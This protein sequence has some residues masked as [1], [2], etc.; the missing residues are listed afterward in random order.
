MDEFEPYYRTYLKTVSPMA[1]SL[2]TCELLA[3]LCQN[4]PTGFKVLDLGSGFSSFY[5]ANLQ[6][7]VPFQLWSVDT[8][9]YWLRKTDKF[10]NAYGL[11]IEN[12][13]LWEE[14]IKRCWVK[15]QVVFFD[16]DRTG[17]RM[18]YLQ[19]ALDNYLAPKGKIVLDDMHKKLLQGQ[20]P[21]ILRL[22]KYSET[23]I[24]ER[25]LDEYG[26]YCRLLYNIER[27]RV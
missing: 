7:R 20:L 2:M 26:R 17:R 5:L 4:A 6:K 12:L 21:G 14:F 24:K 25:T 22:Y 16:I 1:P 11:N 15:F 10:C 8:D 19:V 9:S 13:L 3:E 18:Q 27:K 23:D